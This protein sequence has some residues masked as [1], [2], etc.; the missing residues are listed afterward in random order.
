MLYINRIKSLID[1]NNLT[2]KGFAEK[3][4]VSE[5]G[6][7]S[8]FRSQDMKV[9][10]L[11]RIADYFEVPITY[12]FDDLDS[13]GQTVDFVFDTLKVIVKEKIK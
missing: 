13:K 11:Q 10:T 7:H 2:I 1:E 6:I 4:E 9:S 8:M 3:V 12:F 5:Q